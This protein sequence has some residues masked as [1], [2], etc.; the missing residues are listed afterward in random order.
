MKDN[1]SAC[2]AFVLKQEGGYVDNPKDPGGA[3]LNGVTQGS[4]DLWRRSRGLP[5]MPVRQMEA[6]E[7]D[8]IY[9]TRYWDLI[10]GDTLAKGVDLAVMDPAVNSGVSRAKAWLAASIGGADIDTIKRICAKRLSFLN[11]LGTFKVFG[12]G[13]TRRVA[14]VEATALKMA[15]G[16]LSP[17]VLRQEATKAAKA[18]STSKKT[19]GGA[20][21]SGATLP[22]APVDHHLLIALGVA[23]A[24]IILALAIYRAHV[25][26]TRAEA[27][28]AA[29]NG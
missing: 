15:A 27:L 12:K 18:A 28:K 26:A 7:R 9:R 23:V 4:Y 14:D 21:A 25:N 13:W 2:L 19:A 20:A 6:A 24:L 10:N 3:T 8:L 11:G 17:G 29:A 16:A 1:F 5:L 22:A